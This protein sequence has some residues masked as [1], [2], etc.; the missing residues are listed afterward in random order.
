M[1]DEFFIARKRVEAILGKS[2]INLVRDGIRFLIII[3]KV[4]T[5]YSP[6]KIF[7]PVSVVFLA[8]GVGYYSFTYITTGRF[9]NMS[10]V[11]FTTANIV[12][13]I[14]LVSEQVTT[15]MYKDD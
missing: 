11:L 8:T 4:G 6:L 14:G 2:H 5:I 9:T 7:F 13:L 12:F 3:F 15:L 1:D 10:A